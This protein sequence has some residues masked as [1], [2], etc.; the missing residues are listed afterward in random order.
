MGHDIRLARFDELS[1]IQGYI[2]RWW[3]R[4]HILARQPDL[5]LWQHGGG[6]CLDMV[7]AKE[8]AS[9]R[10]DAILGLIRTSR[11]SG[12]DDEHAVTWMTTWKVRDDQA[13]AG[14]GLRTYYFAKNTLG[15]ANITAVGI[16]NEV[17]K[18]YKALR[19]ETGELGQ[20]V[21]LN[22]AITLQLAEGAQQAMSPHPAVW[23]S[24]RENHKELPP[25][26]FTRCPSKNNRYLVERYAKH[27]CYR[28]TYLDIHIDGVLVACFIVRRAQHGGAQC[29]RGVDFFG[30]PST[31]PM[32]AGNLQQFLIADESEYLDFF[33]NCEEPFEEMGFEPVDESKVVPNH[34]APFEKRNITIRYATRAKDLCIVKGDAD[35]DRPN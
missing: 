12:L 23:V 24:L 21:V 19:F 32:C 7:I 26:F 9:G 20:R 15:L 5:F 17:E 16:N 30:Q 33:T 27:P 28:Y 29:L 34:F 11:Y 14:L 22:P 35:Q 25:E 2:D 3:K 1:E 13:H 6:E 10:L 8:P 4:G 18:L 31:L